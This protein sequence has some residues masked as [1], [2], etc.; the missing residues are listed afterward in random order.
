MDHKIR[1]KLAMSRFLKAMLLTILFQQL[2][3]AGRAQLNSLRQKVEVRLENTNALAIITSLGQQSGCSFYYTA[4][5]LGGIKVTSFLVN[6]TLGLALQKLKA[7]APLEYKV[8]GNSISIQVTTTP[9]RVNTDTVGRRTM[10]GRITDAKTGKPVAYVDVYAQE[11][12]VSAASNGNG[13]FVM[14]SPAA[15]DLLIFAKAGYASQVITV[16]GYTVLDIKLVQ[17]NRT[18]SGVTVSSRRRMNNEAAVLNERQH[19]AVVSDGI[20]AENIEKTAS[21]TTAQAL[22][23]VSGVTITD[24]KY[25]AVRGLGDRSVIGE[26]NGIR[27]ASSD[28]DRSTIPLDLVPA[29]LLDNIVVFKTMTPDRPA[30][31]SGGIVELKTLSIPTKQTL[32]ITAQTGTNSNIGLGGKMNSFY[33]SDMGFS[34]GK[35]KS[36]DLPSD[37]LQLDKQYPGGL[38]QIQQL[39][40]AAKNDPALL[41]EVDRINTIMHHFDPVL[42]TRYKKAPLNGIYNITYGNAFSVFKQHQLGLI[43]SGSYYNRSTDVTNGELNQYSI[44]QGVMTGIRRLMNRGISPLTLP[45]IHPTWESMLA[46]GKIQV[47][48]HLT[49]GYWED[50][51]IVLIPTM[52]SAFSTWAT[53]VEK[54]RLQ[55]LPA[56]MLM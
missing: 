21:I 52:R 42:T 34:G 36:H 17:D 2:G 30:D 41:T 51:R 4:S 18:L 54:R 5:E 38:S 1:K 46:T 31:A 26:L 28:P 23:R 35:I 53:G 3:Y 33:N 9:S 40:S 13:D 11:G 16:N 29:N 22:Q 49:M 32:A 45:P 8:S 19:A 48:K 20:S 10:K 55:V 37:Y 44:Y 43:L 14:Q 50:C 39:V 15:H 12:H 24:D 56:N 25:V 7:L 47:H 6:G 27:L